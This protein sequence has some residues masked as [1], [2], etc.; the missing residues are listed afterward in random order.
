MFPIGQLGRL[1]CALV[2]V[3]GEFSAFYPHHEG[4]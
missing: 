2:M 1:L 4:G 3:A